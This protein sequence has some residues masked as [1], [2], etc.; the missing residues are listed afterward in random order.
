MKDR[1]DQ[2]ASMLAHSSRF[3]PRD[4]NKPQDAHC[5]TIAMGNE[6][7]LDLRLGRSWSS[8]PGIKIPLLRS[9]MVLQAVEYLVEALFDTRRGVS[10][11]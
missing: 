8:D 11:L 5:H 2:L 6:I 9:V 7:M 3:P 1:F 10:F 4:R